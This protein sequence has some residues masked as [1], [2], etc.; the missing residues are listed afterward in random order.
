MN[1]HF[2]ICSFCGRK[3]IC[4]RRSVP[5]TIGSVEPDQWRAEKEK[6]K[7]FMCPLE[8]LRLLNFFYFLGRRRRIRILKNRS[9]ARFRV[10]GFLAIINYWALFRTE[11][12]SFFS[13]TA[14]RY[15]LSCNNYRDRDSRYKKMVNVY[16][17]SHVRYHVNFLRHA[18]WMQGSTGNIFQFSGTLKLA[19]CQDR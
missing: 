7:N 19:T 14:G 8:S 3:N 10:G 1:S 17:T 5:D 6:I 11:E 4:V 9:I 12:Y 13:S 15:E 18:S 2:L 16:T